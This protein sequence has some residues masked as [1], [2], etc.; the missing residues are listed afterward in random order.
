M[1]IK[2][3]FHTRFLLFSLFGAVNE[4]PNVSVAPLLTVEPDGLVSIITRIFVAHVIAA[5]C[6]ISTLE[7]SAFGGRPV[8]L[9]KH[10]CLSDL[11]TGSK[12]L[13]N[14]NSYNM[15]YKL[16]DKLSGIYAWTVNGDLELDA[17]SP[18][19][20]RLSTVARKIEFALVDE[21]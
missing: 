15:Q 1:S 21:L 11:Q 19:G 9:F 17:L 12:D 18:L 14:T 7:K 5:D 20:N 4:F 6:F 16:I 8:S 10:E 13:H 2:L 3:L